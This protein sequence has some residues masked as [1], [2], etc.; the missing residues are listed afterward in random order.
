MVKKRKKSMVKQKSN[1][2]FEKKGI[3]GLKIK[4]MVKE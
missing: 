3:H 2:W 1:M 4:Y